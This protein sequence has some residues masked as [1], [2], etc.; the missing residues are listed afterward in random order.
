VSR[1]LIKSR[2]DA[3]T[4]TDSV[5]KEERGTFSVDTFLKIERTRLEFFNLEKHQVNKYHQRINYI[6][7]SIDNMKELLDSRNIKFVVG[8]YPDEFQ[9]NEYLLNQIFSKFNLKRGNYDIELGQKLL[10]QYLDFK[11]IQYI[12]MLKE[13]RVEGKRR[14]LYLL[15]DT[16]WNDSGNELAAKLIFKNILGFE[17]E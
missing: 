15:R 3:K 10:K 6:F 8:I 14:Q 16:H 2:N 13:F 5:V 12:D 4:A 11:Q 1:E 7:Q 17:K 9:V